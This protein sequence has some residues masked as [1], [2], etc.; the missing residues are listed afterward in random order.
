VAYVSLIEKEPQ[1]E[2]EST[3]VSSSNIVAK[4]D[5]VI[6]EITVKKGNSAVKTGDT[7]TKGDLLILGALAGAKEGE[8]CRAEGQVIGRVSD[9]IC[10]EVDRSYVKKQLVA[11]RLCKI[12]INI[13]KIS[14]NIFEMYGNLTNR[15]GIIENEKE[16]SLPGDKK[17]PFSISLTYIPLYEEKTLEYTDEEL[18]AIASDRLKVETALILSSGD[19]I[20]IST[21]GEFTEGGYIMSSDIVY[22]AEIGSEKTFEI[23]E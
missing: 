12:Q 19:L 8:F 11:K 2:I 13:F 1:S 21:R 15:Y 9:T 17:L 7:V 3:L 22:L 23:T 6:E 4:R 16:Y 20:K 10:V 14:I 18:V 5:S